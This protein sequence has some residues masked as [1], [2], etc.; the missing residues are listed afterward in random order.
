MKIIIATLLTLGVVGIAP[1][2]ATPADNSPILISSISGSAG[3][4]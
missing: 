2:N 1:A 4:E 3:M